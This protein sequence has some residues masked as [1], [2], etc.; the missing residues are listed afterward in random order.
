MVKDA[1]KFHFD[2]EGIFKKNK[3]KDVGKCHFDL[4]GTFLNKAK[5]VGKCHSGPCRHFF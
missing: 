1:D 5:D 3:V 4:E 2:L